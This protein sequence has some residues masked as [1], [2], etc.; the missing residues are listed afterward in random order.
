MWLCLALRTEYLQNEFFQQVYKAMSPSKAPFTN[1][2]GPYTHTHTHTDNDPWQARVTFSAED[3]FFDLKARFINDRGL[4]FNNQIEH[5]SI[6]HFCLPT[7]FI[8][9]SSQNSC[10]FNFTTEYMLI[11][12]SG[13]KRRKEGRGA[14]KKKSRDPEER[15]LPQHWYPLKRQTENLASQLLYCLLKT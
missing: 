9:K 14:G 1:T 2:H 3:I 13:R 10:D 11:T 7:Y 12:Q 5:C 15:K 8:L 4:Y 6:V